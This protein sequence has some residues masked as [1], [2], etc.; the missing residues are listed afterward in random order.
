MRF[1][2]R[3]HEISS[4]LFIDVTQATN[5]YA[6]GEFHITTR[7]GDN[8]IMRCNILLRDQHNLELGV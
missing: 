6:V 8:G 3:T 4:Y 5:R 7:I 2:V 1:P